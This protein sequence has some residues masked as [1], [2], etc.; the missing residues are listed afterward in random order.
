[1]KHHDL[2]F[3]LAGIRKLKVFSMSGWLRTALGG[4]KKT[5]PSIFAAVMALFVGRVEAGQPTPGQ[6]NRPASPLESRAYFHA[7]FPRLV[8]FRG[9]EALATDNVSAAAADARIRGYDLVVAK[10]FDEEKVGLADFALPYYRA[11]KER[12]PKMMFLLHFDGAARDPRDEPALAFPGFWLHR[13]GCRV[14][15]DLP[16]SGETA[17]VTVEDPALFSMSVGK[18]ARFP[19]TMTICAL[20]PDG[21]PDWLITESVDLIAIDPKARRL[22]IRRAVLRSYA[23]QWKAGAAYMAPVAVDGQYDI[24]D[25]SAPMNMWKYNFSLDAP[26]DAQGQ[27]LPE[28]LAADLIR[29]LQPG[30]PADF[31]DGVT[32]D[33]MPFL[34]N[35]AQ[36]GDA[37]THNAGYIKRFG[38]A[39][40]DLDTN[41]DGK[42]DLAVRDGV[43]RFAAG[44]ADLLSRLREGLGPNRL[45]MM[46][47]NRRVDRL[48]N[49]VEVEGWPEYP[50]AELKE[51]SSGVND[52]LFWAAHGA[53]PSVRYIHRYGPDKERTP[54]SRLIMAAAQLLGCALVTQQNPRPTKGEA[55]GAFDEL[56]MGVE[57]RL[58]WLGQPREAARR[59][60]LEGEDLFQGEG[61]SMVKAFQARW[62]SV[63]GSVAFA[64]GPPGLT[65]RARQPEQ[66]AF[67]A[68]L[69]GVPA[70]GADLVI[71]LKVK[72][73]PMRGMP[74]EIARKITVRLVAHGGKVNVGA[75]QWTWA[76]GQWFNPA[77]YFRGLKSEAVDVVVECEDSGPVYIQ[78]VRAYAQVDAMSR[79]FDG[80]L[81][82]AN[83]GLSSRVFDLAAMYPGGKFRRIRG[84]ANQ[85]LKVNNGEP[86]GASVTVAPNDGLF[87]VREQ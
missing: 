2:S 50:D 75:A 33:V 19:D 58:H 44:V 36:T 74:G 87:L 46:D 30:G 56:K 42:P 54:R 73:D 81:V 59:L 7:G 60:A 45:I 20:K 14:T 79:D 24:F 72:A 69:A 16:A 25:G 32:F 17:V 37:E 40:E 65:L 48:L 21:T 29:K 38:Y 11:W 78:D 62:S 18:K 22:T 34:L 77:F 55:W 66:R 23:R 6:E 4:M 8:F 86:V 43:D 68:T 61:A 57:H 53:T 27:H 63:D 15:S 3:G 5:P 64:S 51:W 76:D 80:G 28:M 41:G 47:A 52:Q 70:P 85:D 12:H 10:G 9:L 82:L 31:F 71:A 67:S 13:V 1:M 84:S 49:G 83:P 26:P 35:K 39:L